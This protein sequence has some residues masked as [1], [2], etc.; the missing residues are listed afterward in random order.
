MEATF[1]LPAIVREHSPSARLVY[2]ALAEART[3]L[4]VATL[5]EETGVS[6]DT[7]RRLLG[8]LR[9]EGLVDVDDHPSDGRRKM[10]SLPY[11]HS[12]SDVERAQ[13][14]QPWREV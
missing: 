6:A 13:R 8:Q 9:D 14:Q 11:Q 10:F 4:T 5:V 12:P 1:R 3:P 2:L 7:V